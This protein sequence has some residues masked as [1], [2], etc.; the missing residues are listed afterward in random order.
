MTGASTPARVYLVRHGETDWNAQERA[1]GQI[2][3]PLNERGRAQARRVAEELKDV[4]VGAVYSSDL[5]RA[6]DT[7]AE[8][9]AVHGLEVRLDPDLR[10]IHQGEWQG[11]TNSEIAARWPDLWERRF[12]A[13]RPGGECPREVLERALGALARVASAHPGEHVVVVSHG[14][15]IRWLV[16][17]ALGRETSGPGRVPGLSN[18]GVIV[19]DVGLEAGRP[20][21]SNVVRLDGRSPDPEDPNA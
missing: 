14:A 3:V 4:P 5:R 1:Q 13:R 2:D 15:T 18:G 11:L 6:A 20:H 10:E 19:L 8:I 12:S 7:A 21:L 17:H 9:A 16:A